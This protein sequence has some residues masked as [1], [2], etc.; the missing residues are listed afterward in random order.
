MIPQVV[1]GIIAGMTVAMLS[2]VPAAFAYLGRTILGE[3]TARSP[4]CAALAAVAAAISTLAFGITWWLPPRPHAG[5]I[6][7][8]L[9]SPSQSATYTATLAPAATWPSHTPTFTSTP[10]V[11]ATPSHSPSVSSAI[12][13]SPTPSASTPSKC[14]PTPEAMQSYCPTDQRFDNLT[15][16]CAHPPAE[17]GTLVIRG[18]AFHADFGKYR[19]AYWDPQ[20]HERH[21]L[22][23]SEE[24]DRQTPVFGGRLYEWD[25]GGAIRN[26]GPGWYTLELHVV[27][28]DGNDAYESPCRV[29]VCLPP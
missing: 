13:P 6:V 20:T 14:G 10:T 29:Q 27:K 15:S 11:A 23:T 16:P 19:L 4:G 1:A 18:T 21:D 17:D 8:A 12:P 26:Y 28:R 2:A 3:G 24:E 22:L 25:F 7:P 9:L 5:E